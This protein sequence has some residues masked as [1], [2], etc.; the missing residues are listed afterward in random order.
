MLQTT[1]HDVGTT[2][3]I[4][5]STSQSVAQSSFS[6]I[7]P[8]PPD[9]TTAAVSANPS[10]AVPRRGGYCDIGRR[11]RSWCCH[12]KL[13]FHVPYDNGSCLYCYLIYYLPQFLHLLN[14]HILHFANLLAIQVHSYVHCILVVIC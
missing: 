8:I 4:Q 3:V 1:T 14:F 12:L 5:R 13:L 6:N 11:V 2:T 7:H 10:P 9:T